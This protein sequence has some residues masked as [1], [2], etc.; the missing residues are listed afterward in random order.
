M[1]LK[2]TYKDI[3]MRFLL[4]FFLLQ[5]FSVSNAVVI[6]KNVL[7][8]RCD[9]NGILRVNL[10]L[11]EYDNNPSKF[12]YVYNV[13]EIEDNTLSLYTDKEYCNFLANNYKKVAMKED[14]DY[15]KLKELLVTGDIYEKNIYE[16]IDKDNI[17]ILKNN[18]CV[19]KEVPSFTTTTTAT[20]TN[21]PSTTSSSTLATTTAT[22][23]NTPSTTAS[24]THNTP[25]TTTFITNSPHHTT[26][27]NEI[28]TTTHTNTTSN[29][30]VITNS[31]K[32]ITRENLPSTGAP[33]IEDSQ[34]SSLDTQNRNN[35][36]IALSVSGTIILMVLISLLVKY[37]RNNQNGIYETEETSEE[38]IS[39]NQ[40]PEYEEPN[41]VTKESEYGQP[42][43]GTLYLEPTPIKPDIH[44]NPIYDMDE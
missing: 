17:V 4:P 40:E 1:Y 29:S 39:E 7:K 25:S 43:E 42:N 20:T 26:T 22:T 2:I 28:E 44:F 21:T 38:V 31:S 32:N 9:F 36:I 41:E 3:Y 16:C 6:N 37:K 18:I 15:Y 5:C 14:D 12:K 10:N 8:Q 24:T 30:S 23:N 19:L 11:N 27:T 33:S 13:N 35:L 34:N